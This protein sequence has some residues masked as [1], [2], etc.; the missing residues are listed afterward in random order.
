MSEIKAVVSRREITFV[1]GSGRIKEI[2]NTFNGLIKI[3]KGQ[4][5]RRRRS[6]PLTR[7]PVAYRNGVKKDLWLRRRYSRSE[8]KK[9]KL[10]VFFFISLTYSYLLCCFPNNW[11]IFIVY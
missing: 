8:M 5:G 3:K 9:Q 1:K 10:R 7:L 6:F 4:R 11:K 2:G